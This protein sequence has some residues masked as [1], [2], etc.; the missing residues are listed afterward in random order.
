MVGIAAR[1]PGARN[2]AAFWRNLTESR[3]SVSD[4]GQVRWPG[5]HG[6]AG[7]LEGIE[8]F[9]PAF[10]HLSPREAE[11]MD[12]QHRLFLQE[13]WTALEDAGYAPL[14]LD[15]RR[16]GVFAGCGSGD[17]LSL[18]RAAGVPSEAYSLTGNMADV[19]AARLSYCLN[20]TGP[21]LSV[22]TAC[23][24]SLVATHLAC[25]SL[26]RG[27]C[28]MAIA[29]GVSL[30]TSFESYRVLAQTGMLSPDG[31]CRAFDDRADGFV[32][33]E[34]VAAIVLKPVAAALADADHIYGV[35]KATGINYDGRT[36]GI[37]A[38]S[39]PSQTALEA[40]V[41][42]RFGIDPDTI[43]YIEA[44]GTGTRLGDPIEVAAL[45]DAFRQ[46]TG[47]R[48]FCAIGSVKTN[49]GHAMPA[50][51]LAGLIKVLLCLSHRELVPSLHLQRENSHIDFAGSPFH[52][53]TQ[54]RP[55]PAAEGAPRRAAVSSFGLSGTNAHLVVEEFS[56]SVPPPLEGPRT[57]TLSARD[58]ER[59]AVA[60]RNLAVFL[61]EHSGLRLADVA[62]TLAVGRDAM[63]CRV[64]IEAASL[65]D[66]RH[67]LL[68][69]LPDGGA[70]PAAPPI[71]GARRIP[72]PTYPF[73]GHPFWPASVGSSSL[74][75]G[76]SGPVPQAP[77]AADGRDETGVA[78]ER[79]SPPFRVHFT[80]N[81][82][83]LRDHVISRR[84]VL[85]GVMYLELARA[86]AARAGGGAM[87]EIA[88]V[89]WL[90]PLAV[91]SET[92]Q[93]EVRLRPEAGG[94][95]FEVVTAEGL[96]AKGRLT[97][98]QGQP[99]RLDLERIRARCPRPIGAS[100]LYE[101]LARAGLEYGP[102]FRCVH[103]I[104]A[105]DGE[106][107]AE[108]HGTPDESCTLPPGLLDA[109]LH[110]IA[111]F[112][113]SSD[114]VALPFS[115]GV[116]EMLAALPPDAFVHVTRSARH[117]FQL[118]ITDPAG[119]VCARMR[120]FVMQPIGEAA[121]GTLLMCR[122]VWCEAKP[123]A[124]GAHPVAAMGT[125][126]RY[127]AQPVLLFDTGTDRWRALRDVHGCDAV[128]VTPDE[129]FADIG[130]DRFT[131]R[132]DHAGDY[133]RLWAA[134]REQGRLPMLILHAWAQQAGS[135]DQ[136]LARGLH[137]VAELGRLLSDDP[138][139]LVYL[140]APDQPA[141]SAVRAYLR[142]LRLENARLRAVAVS[143]DGAA[144]AAAIA[145][146][147][148]A[149]LA[150]GAAGVEEVRYTAGMRREVRGLE[151]WQP[152]PSATR[153]RQGGVY[154]ITGGAGGLGR[155]FA[156]H[157]IRTCQARVVLAGRSPLDPQMLAGL[158]ATHIQADVT[159]RSDVD[160][161]IAATKARFGA[162]NGIIHGAGVLRDALAVRQ[163]RQDMDA[164][165][166]P[167]L[168]GCLNL[169]AAASEEPLDFF[170]LCSSISAV[171][172]NAGQAGYAF[173]NAFLNDFAEQQGGRAISIAWP[174]WRDGGMGVDAAVE[175]RLRSSGLEPMAAPAGLR[176]FEQLLAAG[177]STPVVLAGDRRRL[178]EVLG[179][180]LPV[181]AD[182]SPDKAAA[183]GSPPTASPARAETGLDEGTP[184]A[185][186]RE[187]VLA[188]L[189]S[190]AAT[191][192]KVAAAD[193]EPDID[194][195]EYGFDSITFTE[196]ANRLNDRFGCN[197]TP[198]AF[199]EH[200]TLGTFATYLCGA[201]AGELRRHYTATAPSVPA[202]PPPE[203][204]PV[205]ARA[206][207]PIAIVGMSG[208]MPQS[209]DL[210]AFWAHLA[211][212][213]DLIEEVPADRWDW[214]AIYG[215][216]AQDRNKTRAK[217]GGFMPDV[218]R[219]DH[220]FFGI[221]PKEAELMDPQQRLF[222]E[223]VWQAIEN[224]G[225][226]PGDLSG[227]RTGVF[228]GVSTSDY[229]E[230]IRQH[231]PAVEAHITT[232]VSHSFLANRISYLL[233]LRGPSEA[234]DT[235]CSSALIAIH[236]AIEAIHSGSCEM[237]LAGGVN[238][239]A[240]PKLAIA[241]SNAG[242]LS[243]DGRC[244]TFDR[245]ANG[246]VRAEGVGVVLL[247]PLS[248]ALADGDHIHALII[249]SA[250]NHGGH[251]ASPT[252]PNPAAQAD[253]IVRACER[254]GVG[255]DSL[256]YI[257]AHGTGTNLGDPIEI[258]GLKLAFAELARRHNVALAPQSCGI[259]S[260][261][262]NAGHLEAASGMAGLFK[263]VLGMGHR[264]IPASL[265]C[266]EINPYIQL[267]GSPFA[268]VRQAR[269][270]EPARPGMPLRAGLSSFGMGGSNAHLVLEAAPRAPEQS[271]DNAPQLVVLSA[272]TAERLVAYARILADFADREQPD[273]RALACTLWFG[274]TAME[275]RLATVADSV[276][277]L[278][279]KLTAFA[280][281]VRAIDD[282]RVGDIPGSP[283]RPDLPGRDLHAVAAA[284]TAG[285][286][287]DGDALFPAPRP[288]RIPLPAY[289][290]ARVRHWVAD[291]VSQPPPVHAVTPAAGPAAPFDIE[292]H[293]IGLVAREAK[294]PPETIRPERALESYGIDSMMVVALNRE[295]EKVYGELPNTLL[296]EHQSIR[297]LTGYLAGRKRV[298]APPAER[299]AAPPVARPQAAPADEDIAIIGLAGRYPMARDLDAFWENLK[300]GRDCITEIPP[301]RWDYRRYYDPEKGRPDR[302]YSKWGGF[303]DGVD[304]FD[305]LF[306]NI[307]PKEAELLDP[308]ERLFL[309]TA[310][311]TLEDA[312]YSRAGLWD[313]NVGVY[314][315][316]MYGEYQLFGA[317]ELLR[318]NPV[319]PRS[320]YASFAN[321]I[322]YFLNFHGPSMALD[323][324][325]SSSLTAVHL[326]CES[327]R[328]G[329][330][331]L[332]LAGGVNVSLHPL[333]YFQLS[334]GR[335]A[336]SDGR[337]RSFGDGGDGYVPGE[338]VGAVLL[339]PLRLAIA[340][341]D[342]IHAIIK[343]SSINH[344]GKTNGYTV[345]NPTAQS[346]LIAEAFGK[347]GISPASISYVEAHGTGTSLG[348]PIEIAAL[349]RV[350]EGT[351]EPQ[352]CAI[353]SVKSNVGHLESAA[354]IAGLTKV[355]LQMRHRQLV[356]S[357]HA[358]PPNRNIRFGQTPFRVQRELTPWASDGRPRRAAISSFGAGG[359]NAHLILEEHLAATRE[360][361]EPAPEV[362]VLSARTGQQLRQSASN[363]LAAL[364]GIETLADLACTLQ[365]GR[366]ALD[367]RLAFVA[368][369]LKDV[370][371]GLDLWLAEAPVPD[372]A[373]RLHDLARR[374]AGG[375][376]IDWTEH[377]QGRPGRRIG[378]PLYPFAREHYWI[379]RPEV[380]TVLHPETPWLRDHVIG[381]RV[382]LPGVAVLHLVRAAASLP[383]ARIAGLVWLRP[384]V[385][386]R[387]PVEVGIVLRAAEAGQEFELRCG[388]RLHAQGRV[389]PL[390][391]GLDLPPLDLPALRR[392]CTTS[393]SGGEHYGRMAAAGLRYGPAMRAAVEFQSG[394]DT[395]VVDLQAPGAESPQDAALALL[396]GALHAVTALATGLSSSVTYVPYRLDS[397]SF[398]APLP[399]RCHAVARTAGA[400]F[401][402]DVVDPAGRVLVAMRGLEL[403]AIGA[404]PVV[405]A[406]V[407]RQ[408]PEE[409]A[410]EAAPAR[411]GSAI[412]AVADART[413]FFRPVW[414]EAA[415]P[416]AR[417]APGPVLLLGASESR[418]SAL[419]QRLG[420]AVEPATPDT[421]VA[422]LE[423]LRPAVVVHFSPASQDMDV[424]ALLSIVQASP[425]P[426]A[427][428]HVHDG[429]P[430]GAGVAAFC[431]SV[432]Q[433]EPK[434]AFK[435]VQLDNWRQAEDIVAAEIGTIDGAEVRYADARRSVRQLEEITQPTGPARL[436]RQGVYLITGGG[437]GLGRILD[438][439][440]TGDWDARVV[441]A[442]RSTWADPRWIRADVTDP[443]EA[444]ALVAKIIER[445]GALHGVFHCAGELR[446]GLVRHK[447]A[448]DFAAVV[449]PKVRGALNLLKAT[450]D[451]DLDCFVT[452]S[453]IAG[454]F[455]NVGQADYA[456]AN[457]AL[458]V[459]PGATL[460]INWPLWEDGG[461]R[462]SS[463]AIDWLAA[464]TGLVPLDRAGGLRAFE[465]AMSLTERQVVVLHGDAL[466]IRRTLA[467]AAGPQPEV[468]PAPA[469]APAPA[470]ASPEAAGRVEDLVRRLLSRELK[471]P[472]AAIQPLATFD[473]Y[474]IDSVSALNMTRS[475]EE[476][477]GD[478]PKTLLFEHASV[479]DLA[480]H[481]VAEYGERIAG[482]QG[483]RNT[484]RAKEGHPSPVVADA[485]MA[486]GGLAA[487]PAAVTISRDAATGLPVRPVETAGEIAIIG[488][489]GRYPMADDLDAFWSNL[490]NGRDCITEIPP[491]RWDR[492]V[493]GQARWGGFISDVD[494]FDPAAFR[495]SPREAACIDPQERLFL[496]VAWHALE[497]AGYTRT[498]VERREIGVF[499]GVMWGDYQLY[500][501][502]QSGRGSHL[503]P[504]SSFASVANRV[505]YVFDLL[506]PSMAVDTMCSSSLTAI[507][508]ATE[509]IRRGECG[510]AIA[511]GVNLSLHPQKYRQLNQGNFTSSDGRCR[512]FGAGGDGYVPG[513]GVG[514]IILK[515][516]AA[517]LADGDQVYAIVKGSRVNHGGRTS[518][519]TV[520]NPNAQAKVIAQAFERSG[521]D[522]VTLSYIEAHGT[523]TSLGDPIE[524][525]GLAKAFG[526][527]PDQLCAIGSVKSNIGHLE[528]AAGI[529]GITKVLLQMR[530]RQLVPSLH[531]AELN[532]FIRFEET[533]FRVQRD[534]SPWRVPQGQ[535]L[536]AGVS[537]FGAGGSNAHVI[538][539]AYD[540]APPVPSGRP[541]LIVLSAANADRLDDTID[542]LITCIEQHRD[543]LSLDSVACTLQ[544]GREMM[545]ERI[546]VVAASLDEV[547]TVLGAVRRGEAEVAGVFRGSG[548]PSD[549]Y[550][551]LVSGAAGE[552]FLRAII[553][554]NDL[555]KLG[556]LWVAGIPL[557]WHLLY[558]AGMPVRVS[559]PG[560]AFEKRRCWFDLEAP[561]PS[562]PAVTAQTEPVAAPAPAGRRVVLLDP[563]VV[564]GNTGSPAGIVTDSGKHPAD[565]GPPLT[566]SPASAPRVM[567]GEAL[568]L[569]TTKAAPAAGAGWASLPLR[570]DDSAQPPASQPRSV[571]PVLPAGPEP[572][573]AVLKAPV[574]PARTA[575]VKD[576]VLAELAR[577]LLMQPDEIDPRQSFLDL[578]V[579]SVLGVEFIRQI[580]ELLGLDVEATKLYDHASVERLTAYLEPLVVT[581]G[582]VPEPTPEPAAVRSDTPQPAAAA[583]AEAAPRS[584]AAGPEPI[585][586]IGMAGRFP[587]ANELDD[588]WRNLRDGVCSVTEIPPERW[589]IEQYFDPDP[590]APGKSYCK[591]G[592]F[593]A[594][595][596]KFDALFFNISPADAE[597]MDPQ[598]R[599]YL[600][601]AWAALEDAGYSGSAL[602]GARCGAYI[603][604]MGNEYLALVGDRKP[605]QAMLGNSTAILPARIAYVLNLKGPVFA[606]DTACSSSLVAVH[607]ACN[608]LRA[609][610][611]DLMLAGG[612]TLYLTEKP[613]IC[614]SKGGML[615]PDGLCKTFD[616]RANGF[617]PGEAAAV[618]VLKRL[619]RA[620]ADGDPIHG[621]ILG[622]GVNQD[623]HT[624]GLTAPSAD[625]QCDLEVAVYERFGIDPATISYVEAHGTGTKLGD[626]IEV[627][628]LTRAFRRFTDDVGFCRIGSV[629]SNIGHTSAAAGVTGLIKVLLS[630]RHR[631]LPPTL[632]FR[633]DNPHIRFEPSPFR[634]NGSL[635]PWTGERLRA[636]VSSFGFSGTNCHIV[637][638][639]PPPDPM[640]PARPG[641]FAFVLS[642][643]SAERLRAAAERLLEALDGKA[644]L[645]RI[646]WT[647]QTGRTTMEHRLAV[648]AADR[649]EL[650]GVLRRFITGD[651][652]GAYLSQGPSLGP[653]PGAFGV[654][655][656]AQLWTNGFEVDW[657]SLYGG[658]TPRRV[659][660]P[661]YPFAR[662]RHWVTPPDAGVVELALT[663]E[664]PN[665]RDHVV[666][667]RRV[668]PG[669]WYLEFARG[670]AEKL[671][672]EPVRRIR[673]VLWTRPLDVSDGPALVQVRFERQPGSAR[674]QA[675]PYCRGLVDFGLPQV[676][677]PRTDIAALRSRCRESMDGIAWYSRLA[678]RGLEYGPSF[679]TVQRVEWREEAFAIIIRSAGG[680][681]EV[682]PPAS[683]DGAL[684]I[685]AALAGEG[686]FLP[687]SIGEIGISGPLPSPC[688]VH[689]R[690]AGIEGRTRRFDLDLMDETGQAAITVRDFAISEAGG[691]DGGNE[692]LYFRPDWHPD[693][694]A[695]PKA[696]SGEPVLLLDA[697]DRHARM[698]AEALQARVEVMLPDEAAPDAE[699]YP[700]Q[701][702]EVRIGGRHSPPALTLPDLPHPRI[703]HLL[704]QPGL[705]GDAKARQQRSVHA[706]FRLLRTAPA[707]SQVL[708]VHDGQPAAA[709]LAA[710]LKSVRRERAGFAWK[711]VELDDW[712]NVAG[713]IA[714]EI[715]DLDGSEIRYR[716][717]QR[718]RRRMEEIP[719]PAQASRLRRGGVYLITGGTG[720]LGRLIAHH[721][722]RSCGARVVLAGRNAPAGAYAG[723]FVQADVTDAE[724]VRRLVTEVTGRFGALHGVI[725]AAGVLR[726]GLL[727]DK[728]EDDLT[729]VLAPKIAGALNLLEATAGLPLDFFLCFSSIA[730]VVGNA[731]QA[732]YAYANSYLDALAETSDGRITSINWPLWDSGGM[733]AAPELE[734]FLNS[735]G[736]ASLPPEQGLASFDRVLGAGLP[737]AMVLYGRRSAL[738]RLVAPPSSVPST[739]DAGALAPAVER[740][741]VEMAAGILKI[742][743]SA[744]DPGKE[745]TQYGVDSIGFVEIA[746]SLQQ[747][748]GIEVPPT[749]VFEYPSIRALAR[750]LCDC[751]A[752]SLR[753]RFP[754]A[755]PPAPAAEPQTES[756]MLPASYG[757]Q[758]LWFLYRLLP[759]SAAY[760]VAFHVRLLSPLDIAALRRALR[761]LAA[762]H[763]LLR[764]GF[765]LW[766]DQIICEVPPVRD[767]PVLTI[768]AAGWD[769]PRLEAAV[770]AA[771]QAPFD[772][773][774]GPPL[775]ARVFTWVDGESI[776]LL[777]IHH[778]AIDALSLWLV[779]GELG[780]LYE[781]EAAGA[782][783]ALPP[784]PGPYRD[785]VRWQREMVVS[786]AGEA[787]WEYWRAQLAEPRPVT[788]LPADRPRSAGWSGRGASMGLVLSD[789]LSAGVK[790]LAQGRSTTPFVVMLTAFFVWLHRWTGEEDLVIGSPMAG[791]TRPEFARTVGYLV[792]MVALR[793]DLSGSPTGAELLGRV[794]HMVFDAMRH[795]D[796][797]FPLLVERLRLDRGRDQARSPVFQI[798]F[799]FQS[800]PD[801]GG[802]AGQLVRGDARE[803][804]W[805]G[806]R[807]APFPMFQQ[808]GQFD[809]SLDVMPS[810]GGYALHLSYDPDLFDAATI[811]R[812]GEQFR[813][814]LEGLVAD[815]DLPV[816]RL[817]I[818]PP[819]ERRLVVS[820]WNATDR[821]YR[822]DQPLHELLEE[823]AI[824]HAGR[825]AV[826]FQDQTLTYAELDA[827]ANRLATHLRGLGVG[828]DVIVGVCLPRSLDLVVALCGILKAGGAY[829][830]MDTEGPAERVGFMVED[831]GC[832]VVVTCDAHAGWFDTVAVVRMDGDAAVLAAC[833]RG[834]P[835]VAVAPGNLAYVIYTS[836]TTGRP[837]GVMNTHRGICNRLLWAQE[838]FGLTEADR[839]LQKTPYTFDVSVWEFFWPLLTGATLVVVPPD[840]HRD[841]TQLIDIIRREQVTTLHF[842]P[843]MLRLFLEEAGVETCTSLRR[844]I[845]SGEA[846]PPE[847]AQRFFSRL[848]CE[849]HNLYGPTEAAIDVTAWRCRPGDA[850]HC[851]PIGRP[852]ANTRTYVLDRLM[853]PVPIGVAGEL[854]IGGVGV[855]PGYCN[856][857]E[858]TNE[859]F[860]PDPFGGG[861]D[862]RLYRTGDVARFLVD[863]NIEYLGRADFQVKIRGLRIE[864]NEIEAVLNE[865]PAVRASV[866]IARAVRGPDLD[867]V[868]YYV[869]AAAPPDEAVLKAH[870]AVVL[871]E[872]M[873]PPFFVTLGA[874]PLSANGKLNRNA[875]PDPMPAETGPGMGAPLVTETEIRLADIWRE[876]LRVPVA[877]AEAHFFHLGGHSLL[878]GQVM[879]R[880]RDSFGVTLRIADLFDTPVLAALARR[881]ETAR[882]VAPSEPLPGEAALSPAQERMWFLCQLEGGASYNVPCVLRIAGA[883]DA[884]RLAAAFNAVIA[885]HDA[886]RSNIV[887]VDGLPELLVH[888]ERTIPLEEM[889]LPGAADI[890]LLI[891][892]RVAEPFDLARDPL[893]RVSLLRGEREALLVIVIHHVVCDGWSIGVLLREVAAFYAG[894]AA[895]PPLPVQYPAV[896]RRQ[897]QAL[898]GA[899]MEQDLS[900]WQS[901][902]AGA[903]IV[904]E[905]PTD[906]PRPAAQSNEGDIVGFKIDPAVAVRLRRL[907][908]ANGCSLFMTLLAAFGAL[909]HRWSGETDIV[910]GTPVAG[911]DGSDT[912]AL[913]G[914]FVNTVVLRTDLA[915]NPDFTELLQRVRPVVL[916]AL[917]HQSVPFGQVVD[918]IAPPR[919]MSCAP[920]FQV[921][922]SFQDVP[923]AGID[924]GGV[925]TMP[926]RL[927][928]RTGN[929][930]LTL[931]IVE[932]QGE[933]LGTFE[934]SSDLF[935]R[936]TIER[937]ASY[938]HLILRAVAAEPAVRVGE[939][940]LAP[941]AE[942]AAKF[943]RLVHEVIAAAAERTPDAAALWTEDGCWTYRD[944]L[945]RA[946]AIAA[947]LRAG[948]GKS[949]T[950]VAAGTVAAGAAIG[951]P[952]TGRPE[953]FAAML[954]IFLAGLVYVPL[955]PAAPET[956]NAFIRRDAGIRRLAPGGSSGDEAYQP[957]TV[958]ATDPAYIIYTSGST[959]QP[960]GVAVSYGALAAHCTTIQRVYEISSADRVLQWSPMWFDGSLEQAL[961][962]L[963]AGGT[964]VLTQ[965]RIW[966]PSEFS[967]V[968]QKSG[969][970][971]AEVAPS[972]LHELLLGWS[973][974]P[975][976]APATPLRILAVGGDTL[977]PATVQLWQRMP[978]VS[979]CLLNSY[980]PTE[981]AIAATVYDV[982]RNAPLAR[983]PIGRP[984][985][986]RV[987][988]VLDDAG[989]RVP[990]GMAGEIYVGGETLAIGYINRPDLTAEKF[991]RDPF[992]D[993]EQR[994]YRTGDR[995]RVR[996]DGQI[997]FLG[998]VDLQVKIRGVRI[999]LGEIEAVLACAE[1000]V[1001][1002]AAA[1003]T[1004]ADA[1005]GNPVLIAYAAGTASQKSLSKH[1006][1007]QRLPAAMQPA[1008]IV[1009]RSSLPHTT[1010]GKI[1011]RRALQAEAARAARR[1012]A[1013]ATVAPRDETERRLQSIW[1014]EVLNVADIGI[1015]DNF[1016]D[1017][1018]GHSLLAVRLMSRI[1019]SEF[1020]RGLPLDALLDRAATIEAQAEHLR[1021]SAGESVSQPGANA[1022]PAIFCMHPVASATLM[1023]RDLIRCLA[1024][1025]R[1026]LR[1027]LPCDVPPGTDVEVIAASA[1028]TALRRLQPAG[1029][1030]HLLGW[1031][1032]GG[1033][1034]AFEMA[1035]QLAARGE[1036]VDS[1037][1038]LIDSFLARDLPLPVADEEAMLRAG[1039]PGGAAEL[1040]EAFEAM[1041]AVARSLERY[1042]PQR[1043]DGPVLLLH[1044]N[1045]SV[1046]GGDAG[1047]WP[1048]I[1049]PRLRI[1050]NVPGN[1051]YTMLR[1052]PNTGAWAGTLT[1053]WLDAGSLR[1054]LT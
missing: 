971:V 283:A 982:P 215:D 394:D 505:S 230:L 47:R 129:Q 942:P 436:R 444:Q 55:W 857:P 554:E 668:V 579:D 171:F 822:L 925:E 596:D 836:G 507:H 1035:C 263:L 62:H 307:S 526:P 319:A 9:D 34:G 422:A 838:A 662:D 952:A 178:R 32:P 663:G 894:A 64:A 217:W 218:D 154:I 987:V 923:W 136:Q 568:P 992:V 293:L 189:A 395:A 118:T 190:M 437:G 168:L 709:A 557:D 637:V 997:E 628:A 262:T 272:R 2:V 1045:D 211:A 440:L 604:V 577:V 400:N 411:S 653:L 340:D 688:F 1:L 636:A 7:L 713:V 405:A 845:C 59:L 676:A 247:K 192:L 104:L 595:A 631:E 94:F 308:Q 290:F 320:T 296:F 500:G 589:P 998:R 650:R 974:D 901:Q 288:N 348:D 71:Q 538:L 980:G 573:T 658:V 343:A 1031:S 999:E 417:P 156:E 775:G 243:D 447:S 116:F 423:R 729:A 718:S 331:E 826:V 611:A 1032:A 979:E 751:H 359:S 58:P 306:F 902:L 920:L 585:A 800:V 755:A 885:R 68:Q 101:Q 723:A 185:M 373:G 756:E 65:D 943:V 235:A 691:H 477:F 933:L 404:A 435:T 53:N 613:Y 884:D 852:I 152:P 475:L 664:E 289:P 88:D 260:V 337:C 558:P 137:S 737:R 38:P 457:A 42:R 652:A 854:Y 685:V 144:D 74:R 410:M 769:Q 700:Q 848:G 834:M 948:E 382:I 114:P 789:A 146:A 627:D 26:R 916:E 889:P 12:P 1026:V 160:A 600:E 445:H 492:S 23:S 226:R 679:Q 465:A 322:S 8:L 44:H 537:S 473:K 896:A 127:A 988:Y 819:A 499:V 598:Q 454:L 1042:V 764:A 620:L 252:A 121:T 735:L 602:N 565:I 903:P 167:K 569:M 523:G 535:P 1048:E 728:A 50:S 762:R 468:T 623:G 934:Y 1005:A 533:P 311:H 221:S 354:G 981:V 124:S 957:V 1014:S 610:E 471:L 194:V 324:M 166:A 76:L 60:A 738:L 99:E 231:V 341:G 389:A 506:G 10:F 87:G 941:A 115:L 951:V 385:V 323:T 432:R 108:L 350:F 92:R 470:A 542:R 119:N 234:I 914:L 110:S 381:G 326:A 929:F 583:L 504:G 22:Q 281:G 547:C 963:M 98:R 362:I 282:V 682:L 360:P 183:P 932:Q 808:E 717:G 363:L 529:A 367:T 412:S 958:A 804:A 944:L 649:Q 898:A 43:T 786:A 715:G 357:L 633:R 816:G 821:P 297:A 345:P 378:L 361:A 969:L 478:L 462:A 881:V 847:L 513:E 222:L 522:P 968:A 815:P 6:Q 315:G 594:D 810:G 587:G 347:A 802:M 264:T 512:S 503:L 318:G 684:Q 358:D 839:V 572:V 692:T 406:C 1043:Y 1010:T 634:V 900:Y 597:L 325:C 420:V 206:G 614:M 521:C 913:I 964:V 442:G 570:P 158:D 291:T 242:M 177:E 251:A 657:T 51:G 1041:R 719:P 267:E 796:Y 216:P 106:A 727:C 732:G 131:V 1040:D 278:H 665:L 823:A 849:L 446:D 912:E 635:T 4:I 24:S 1046:A 261:K 731:G 576:T 342:R 588:F 498:S 654:E 202:A 918:A 85:P 67:K 372:G 564:A 490:R 1021:G 225:Y 238:V 207:D 710:F 375:A 990:D 61:A 236:R 931:D 175:Q 254:A 3:E 883:V 1017:A 686:A 646:A 255:P 1030:Y 388:E 824:R 75:T 809:L 276:E 485:G 794:R 940:G 430:A 327:L 57:V 305:P 1044:A 960:K 150:D 950:P 86:A 497:D 219:F 1009:V 1027:V 346:A 970:T 757:Q 5:E 11:L 1025:A 593:L 414:V 374:W 748:Y 877:G 698:L 170:A 773:E 930:D 125:G 270:F 299:A 458:D 517:A 514:A 169:A 584:V 978:A 1036:P 439:H 398:F 994:M 165:I 45:T 927:E 148:G 603:G 829:L 680:D 36:N 520:P 1019:E 749:I 476:T 771:Y 275:E 109:A 52:V 607:Q 176:A 72:L 919:S 403:R 46:F 770:Q 556:R 80:G 81:E 427:L 908:E 191:V 818:L 765:R 882:T 486:D 336:A 638:E 181:T 647:L 91:G 582:A 961:P 70:A 366:E 615:S 586:I 455:G 740:M 790:V 259:G 214:R 434:F 182:D 488:V 312:G 947:S 489:A 310:W 173:A 353:G 763:E 377:R 945:G 869:P 27:E 232:G 126:A 16:C 97:T 645:D 965:R 699:R 495:I 426:P 660:L 413:L 1053:D 746:G 876:V 54:R 666:A 421:V 1022:G 49:I 249:G 904:L 712:S 163:T 205:V 197:V 655:R 750:Y 339:K 349:G 208:R 643:R 220:A 344:G 209:A 376:D 639:Q 1007:A 133:R 78:P 317:E 911:R 21:V 784:P 1023:Y 616:D 837:K 448:A 245:R 716:F 725:H 612:V 244:K 644:A 132:P 866:V 314:V 624:N 438:G 672:N 850:L 161:L 356:P 714:D 967:C 474:G 571:R 811:E 962:T 567:D 186:T 777:T 608:T 1024:P 407:V 1001:A 986:G 200:T 453:S 973:A 1013:T 487:P 820:E 266:S 871:P 258:N 683:L 239:M 606:L 428:L 991:V 827:A 371:T 452:F 989:H 548:S 401:D 553:Q 955:E 155:L 15:G 1011:D 142:T 780:E 303:L 180:H 469:R 760:H 102:G 642:A 936:P 479:A 708:V 697:D 1050:S 280:A 459:L 621:V 946:R 330:S 79:D 893:L 813:T 441:P 204:V 20:L 273:L 552:S 656:L 40:E 464:N 433:E 917:E 551:L 835:S 233:N 510:M 368:A 938:F 792:S 562:R 139:P 817:P 429:N 753:G 776:L 271:R 781:A 1054:E 386:E 335:F 112:A 123:L 907:A 396:D 807:T 449:A 223:T 670:A 696:P 801:T 693:G 332:A 641:P 541:C 1037:L 212:G 1002:E 250:E 954:G 741:L 198:A 201:F 494:R 704:S 873:I 172:G 892:Q 496:Q 909:L 408:E 618:V 851:M 580:N 159:R 695:S 509:A 257:E 543:T 37:T 689:V 284:W 134:L 677:P 143:L 19:L 860:V 870:L 843:S 661:S 265:H 785:F 887:D 295:L 1051:H 996:L 983:V 151:A 103:R 855:A 878:A 865:H 48:Q 391:A 113:A 286:E 690:P 149:A 840:A 83:F 747:S 711:T 544:V 681:G 187:R 995:G 482:P 274:R 928:G 130:D 959:G 179:L 17:Y 550:G 1016:F 105:G 575:Y 138:V 858:L 844:V 502:E 640:A 555:E 720:G 525:A 733:H 328:R 227:S 425:M 96:H 730:A 830:P 833:N 1020:G 591:A 984:L 758:A 33:A 1034:V 1047:S 107:L 309:E 673:D 304:L 798:C 84:R 224:A 1028:L 333:K 846:L 294:I 14:S 424:R 863:G 619:D 891:G 622:S 82:P 147:E 734:A 574:T 28:E 122:P 972:Y 524:I 508:L 549:A 135:L 269:R 493:S 1000:G 601:T 534:L 609:G 812:M 153:L 648:L 18:L 536:R 93:A 241:F 66:L 399:A 976:S 722:Q 246:Y 841:S 338:G 285:A 117:R 768:D 73:A 867:L 993:G 546:A 560:Y 795:Q 888:P 379:S 687:L 292:E 806:M 141:C 229:Y 853:Q 334:Q 805:G 759:D 364:D 316:V 77:A 532:P 651:T 703:V 694:A 921:M 861:P 937:L 1003:A 879:A 890:R 279:R 111:A 675:G 456:Y 674:F 949:L 461:M 752:E 793:A 632:H 355:L 302:I 767:I 831:A 774:R 862:G 872:A 742:A 953:A 30:M 174:L 724:D 791:R 431:R 484:V 193:F 578:G 472:L 419:R 966:T 671:F 370:R 460:S 906:R 886:L 705:G 814:L 787:H 726:D 384:V 501:P 539:E 868:A 545:T 540:M 528:S 743:P 905:L 788:T 956:R 519:Y 531:S 31:T 828:P 157:L 253:V 1004:A 939:I 895:L 240:S 256:A 298:G 402:I 772:L 617:V 1029:P 195:S 321:R 63:R 899:R 287:V 626:P 915:G 926:V 630:L 739:S 397:V 409:P 783:L 721:L 527:R 935:D 128:L 559:L 761:T 864:P 25:E 56:E 736:I 754:D 352:S 300:T 162:V 1038:T 581:E 875:L 659:S 667:G 390:D 450:A 592:G 1039:L 351:A 799:V 365:V 467:A 69:P 702:D 975:A 1033:V 39:A 1015:C 145:L 518:G 561:R 100:E 842:V 237:A 1049:A 184:P 910:V 1006:L 1012:T 369:S 625:S 599:I 797:P 832:P 530:H 779:I 196:L 590:R 393:T 924:L 418:L 874:L 669:T 516:L 563:M 480:A 203:A 701:G 416:P 566:P 213:D 268:I 922:F 120:D 443:A 228:A 778:I 744:I 605:A 41:Y 199:F 678:A 95:A 415:A 89:V 745:L 387:E 140:H 856:R 766:E 301:E 803:V 483:D 782:P 188:D 1018:G 164:V 707:A 380:R 392:R 329:E 825:D 466:R 210:A 706:L 481:L 897:L 35:I 277:D 463:R 29:G 248:R 859:R 977:M 511:G 90:R 313:R 985:P 491:E 515:P 880:I 451:C 383:E 629:K 1008:A 13:A 1052:E